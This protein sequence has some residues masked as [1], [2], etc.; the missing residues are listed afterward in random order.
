MSSTSER[1]QKEEDQ[2]IS[3]ETSSSQG[4]ILF[5][6]NFRAE[7][8]KRSKLRARWGCLNSCIH[9]LNWK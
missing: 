2:T 9:F 6:T 8:Q 3:N 1:K 7:V 5:Y 4:M